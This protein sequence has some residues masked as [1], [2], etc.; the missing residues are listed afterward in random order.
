MNLLVF[1]LGVQA[2][3]DCSTLHSDGVVCLILH[4]ID[5]SFTIPFSS[6]VNF[7]MKSGS[8]PFSF[9][10]QI[11]FNRPD[12]SLVFAF[13][14]SSHFFVISSGRCSNVHLSEGN[15]CSDPF[16]CSSHISGS[17]DGGVGVDA[18]VS[19]WVGCFALG[20]IA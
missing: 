7:F 9:A 8:S 5:V 16:F 4:K 11:S 17:V 2:T 15:A 13:M 18:A 1:S 14:W 12:S 20:G 19:F 10:S 3:T 6:S